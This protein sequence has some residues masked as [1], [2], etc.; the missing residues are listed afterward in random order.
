MINQVLDHGKHT[1]YERSSIRD[2]MD[3]GPN[4]SLYM[5]KKA[6]RH[7]KTSEIPHAIH[8]EVILPLIIHK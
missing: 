5:S 3:N 8:E 1:N 6:G 4:Q 7:E 2:S